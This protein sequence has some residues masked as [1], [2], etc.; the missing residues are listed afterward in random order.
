MFLPRL[1]IPS[2]LQTFESTSVT[3]QLYTSTG[4]NEYTGTSDS[5]CFGGSITM[6]KLIDNA[7]LVKERKQRLLLHLEEQATSLRKNLNE[8]TKQIS[9]LKRRKK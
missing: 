3:R 8:I 1:D 7:S 5:I 9:I 2:N 6:R 4:N